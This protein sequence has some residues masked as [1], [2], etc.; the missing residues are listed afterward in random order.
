M[1]KITASIFLSLFIALSF[2]ACNDSSN[3]S[4]NTENSNEDYWPTSVDNSWV[5]TQNSQEKT[6]K[7]IGIDEIDGVKYYKFSQLVGFES[8][9]E[10]QF[11]AWIKKN[12]DEYY[13]KIDD[14]IVKYGD[15]TGKVSGYQ[16]L[17]FKDNLAVN[18][19][20]GGTYNYTI[21]YNVPDLPNVTT[22]ASY[23]GTILEKGI[24]LTLN[25]TI[26]NDVIKFRFIQKTSINGQGIS[27]VAVDFWIAKNIG[28][29]KME[30]L[31]VSSELKSYV[32]K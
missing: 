17:L 20:W 10:G 32:I 16:F 28:I 27:E 11:T 12:N 5:Y 24:S 25:G 18:Q 19:S 29:I 6:M 3:D 4:E 7:I 9:T 14:I 15:N 26:Y 13:I 22:K 30:S 23:T 1:K 31:G 2:T 8:L 21:N